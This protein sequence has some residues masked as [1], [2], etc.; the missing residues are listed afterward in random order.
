MIQVKVRQLLHESCITS[1]RISRR[2]IDNQRFA[3]WEYECASIPA[4][5]VSAEHVLNWLRNDM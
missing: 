1:A 3:A 4:F 2:I 5:G